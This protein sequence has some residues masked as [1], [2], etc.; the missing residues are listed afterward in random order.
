[1]TQPDF[2]VLAEI[3]R[4]T[5]EHGP[6]AVFVVDSRAIILAV[7]GQAE[8]LTGRPRK[9]IIGEKVEALIPEDRRDAH[10]AHRAAYLRNPHRRLMGPGL[11]L[12]I[13]QRSEEGETP[14]AVDINL[15]PVPIST[16]VVIVLTVRQRDGMGWTRD[17]V[18]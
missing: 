13:L 8:L 3:H 11:D 7:N 2:M 17:R 12:E 1:M 15:A 5:F 9:D 18:P 14:I 10:R 6:D 4:A 16:G